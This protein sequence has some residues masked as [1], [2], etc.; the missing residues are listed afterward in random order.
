MRRGP[1][2]LFLACSF[3]VGQIGLVQGAPL[4]AKAAP[5]S[6]Y[7]ILVQ[8]MNQQSLP[9]FITD[10]IQKAQRKADALS[11]KILTK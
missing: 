1:L 3:L 7:K 11:T 9:D 6:D 5:G 8:K 2:K 4:A 10:S